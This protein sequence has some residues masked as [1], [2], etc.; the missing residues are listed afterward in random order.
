VTKNFLK[1]LIIFEMANNHMGQ[2]NHGIKIIN[3]YGKLIKKFRSNFDF[4]FKLQYRNLPSFIH[5][6]FKKRGDLHYVKRFND[7]K[8]SEKEF[9]KLI[10]NIKKNKFKTIATPFD[11]IS[12][13]MIE[14]QNL[15]FIKVASCSFNDWP[16]LESIVK[17]NKP[18][19]LSTAGAST[20]ALD[21]VV[22]F[23][24][25]RKKEFAL[26]HCVAEYPTPKKKL[27]LNQ[28]DY[29]KNRYENIPIGYSSHE[30][31]NNFDN[32]KIAVAKGA[33]IFE[34]HVGL[35][36][37]NFKLNKYSLS[38]NQTTV[39]VKSLKDT[40]E[41]CGKLNRKQTTNLNEQTSLRSLQRGAYIKKNI[42]KNKYVSKKEIYFAF[43]PQKNQIL[44]ND[45]SKYLS[46]KTKTAL[47]KNQP[48]LLK[49]IIVK[50]NR[51]KVY[52][53][54]KK[55]SSFIKKSQ[56]S[57]PKN[58]NIE[59][60]HH[61]GI[62][63]FYR[64]GL[65]MFTIVNREYC[66]KILVVLPNQV[67]PTQFHKKKEETF[68]ILHGKL[69]LILNDKKKIL[70]S[71]DVITIKPGQTHKFYS[72]KGCIIE[73]ISTTHIKTDSFYVDKKID[74]NKSRKTIANFWI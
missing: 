16:L 59:I 72:K 65:S 57:L 34:K 12:V 50:D 74:K 31:P 54:I 6:D 18:I 5:K 4:A 35:E 47:K 43:P 60:S 1:K 19:I 28:I 20:D 61:Y 17:V 56:I 7:T 38:P 40:I 14:K 67:H 32:V 55:V 63:K 8:L 45:Y 9:N 42:G 46:I 10:T 69:I 48:L 24:N 36:T 22:F 49:K 23:L 13:K 26:M 29:L 2:I 64:Y 41:V 62:D 3:N 15:D 68:N 37:K 30:F 66:K 58:I 71:G 44:A 73:E 70:N 51:Q 53:I 27:N 25:N 39:W 52:E 11:E 33:Q 21:R